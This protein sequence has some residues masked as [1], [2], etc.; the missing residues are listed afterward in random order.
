MYYELTDLSDKSIEEII[1]KISSIPAETIL[2][3]LREN[4]LGNKTGAELARAL[5]AIPTNIKTLSLVDNHFNN[6][7]G[8]ELALAFAAIPAGVTTLHLGGNDL[9]KLSGAELALAF[10]AI[11]TSVTTLHLNSNDLHNLSA[12]ELGIAFAAIPA[13]VSTLN[14]SHNQLGVRT[15][16]T[17]MA[18]AFSAIPSGVKTLNLSANNL[19]Y[20]HETD[21]PVAFAAI[22]TSV[23]TLDLS[24]Q[25]LF[26]LSTE[27]MA[28][29][30]G[31]L[32]KVQ[33]IYL[34]YD[35]VLK[36]DDEKR[37][38]L[39]D[40]FPNLS[41]TIFFDE[42]SKNILGVPGIGKE[43]IVTDN[44]F[45]RANLA[46]RLGFPATVEIPSLQ[47]QATFFAKEKKLEV[48]EL[49]EQVQDI[50]KKS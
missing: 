41:N 27:G 18:I 16:G 37:K 14:L 46:K 38:A 43:P 8:A 29:L 35:D 5:A 4:Y 7:S 22:P 15:T 3:N 20:L 25:R 47:S 28:Q 32:F 36:M 24:N 23:T 11:P 9:G 21:W 39:K 26:I 12:D 2:L 33:T 19:E 31:S 34:S 49:P 30:S 40:I 17:E 50:V 10:A 48:S 45:Q 1:L 13:G 42:Y 44:L 6:L